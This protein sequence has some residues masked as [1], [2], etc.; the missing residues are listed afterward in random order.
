VTFG[1]GGEKYSA[2]FNAGRRIGKFDA[3]L[4]S[5]YGR[6]GLGPVYARLALPLDGFYL[7][8]GAGA[9]PSN[10]SDVTL[11]FSI[12]GMIGER[13]NSKIKSVSPR[14]PHF[15]GAGSGHQRF[16][17]P[18]DYS[19]RQHRKNVNKCSYDHWDGSARYRKLGR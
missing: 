11:R 1:P 2:S 13:K 6:E 18:V 9:D 5:A 10:I 12:T 3:A 15:Q 14:K 7:D 16:S 4:S 17:V 19:D 8:F